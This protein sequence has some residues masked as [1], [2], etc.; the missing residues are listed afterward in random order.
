MQ[1]KGGRHGSFNAL[2]TRHSGCSLRNLQWINPAIATQND[3]FKLT[4]GRQLLG[5]Y[6]LGGI[7]YSCLLVYTTADNA[8]GTSVNRI[9]H[10]Q[11]C[12]ITKIFWIKMKEFSYFPSSS[13]MSYVS[14]KALEACI[15]AISQSTGLFISLYPDSRDLGS[16]K[17]PAPIDSDRS[18][19][20]ETVPERMPKGRPNNIG[21][22]ARAWLGR[23]ARWTFLF[24]FQHVGC[25][26]AWSDSGFSR[27]FREFFCSQNRRRWVSSF[28]ISEFRRKR[29][30]CLADE[31]I[32]CMSFIFWLSLCLFQVM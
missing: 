31:V 28:V 10:D 8:K 17:T 20:S 1:G 4:S 26:S 3:Q 6:N 25:F 21:M 2:F 12:T 27:S 32:H 29:S 9:L 14:W 7:L 22:T 30:L 11:F 5:I 15:A 19:R 16:M 24:L 18:D 23:S 13:L